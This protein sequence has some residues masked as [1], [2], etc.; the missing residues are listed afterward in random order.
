M[1]ETP[2]AVTYST[3]RAEDDY[4]SMVDC[5]EEISEQVQGLEVSQALELDYFADPRP[6]DSSPHVPSLTQV[7]RL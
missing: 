2:A 6:V 7:E 3:P 1:V 4:F 5:M